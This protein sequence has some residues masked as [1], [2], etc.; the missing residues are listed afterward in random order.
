MTEKELIEEYQQD[1]ESEQ[2]GEFRQELKDRV[3]DLL[4]VRLHEE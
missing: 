3:A 2:S 4:R 1:I